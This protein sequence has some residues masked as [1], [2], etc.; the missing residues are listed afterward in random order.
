M[1]RPH[2]FQF[3]IFYLL[4]STLGFDELVTVNDGVLRGRLLT[5][6][7]NG[8]FR[9][10][11]GVPYA[12][13]PLGSLRFQAPINRGPWE[14]V[15]NATQ[16]SNVCYAIGSELSS[17]SED[18]LYLNVYTPILTND[19]GSTV[20]VLVWIHGGG[21][22]HGNALYS[23]F[24]PDF[25]IEKD[26]V[27]VTV[28]YR[29]GPF[30]FLSTGDLV[31]PGNAGH[32]DQAAAIKWTFENIAAFG[33][34]PAKITLAGQS[35]GAA[36]VGY[37]L[38]YKGNE[39]LI[40]AAI[41]ESGSP[42][43]IWSFQNSSQARRYAFDL[44]SLVTDTTEF[45]NDS[46]LLLQFLQDVDA[47]SLHAASNNLTTPLPVKE[48]FH[49]AAFLTGNQYSML[50][51]GNFIRVPIIIGTNSEEEIHQAADLNKLNRTLY[52]YESNNEKFIPSDFMVNDS[53][54]RSDIA[55]LIRN[56]YLDGVPA[57]EQM[58]HMVRFLSH[59][60]FTNPMIK[61]ANLASNYTD[62]Y[63]YVFSYDGLMGNVNVT[64]KGADSVDHAEDPKYLFKKVD[65]SY[66]NEDLSKFPQSDILTHD[67]L[68]ELWV[69]FVKYLNPTP[70]LSELLQNVTW[71][72]F[73][74]ID[75]KYL[76]IGPQLEVQS[77]PKNPYY[78]SWVEFY[79]K[80]AT[81]PF[82]TF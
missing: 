23:N 79:E 45:A 32:K 1:G 25:L 13:P 3:L 40:R 8:T 70:E 73:T 9:A 72:K 15:L 33:G 38:L 67:R 43:S 80:W 7:K 10:F 64:I 22:S 27:I 60:T 2:L 36:S 46:Q 24:G 57:D 37:Q 62:V 26:I 51:A 21:Y 4:H 61:H 59:T 35:A 56:L 31:V 29:L 77:N 69:N 17:Q 53:L 19:N 41:L 14:G 54:N 5:T 30:G 20:P 18:C 55:K 12:K 42:L 78:T 71:P 81:K 63:F 39:G 50:E 44:G 68:I 49:D 11:Q 75:A 34:D 6:P 52:Q 65:S 76:N 48:A 28:S 16:D 58:G 47:G 82:T 66:S 74:E